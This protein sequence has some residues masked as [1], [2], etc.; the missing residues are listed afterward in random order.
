MGR[1]I[2]VAANWPQ[3]KFRPPNHNRIIA[4]Q[5]AFLHKRRVVYVKRFP[6]DRPAHKAPSFSYSSGIVGTRFQI[7]ARE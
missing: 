7:T 3:P 5:L 6:A 4:V 2:V 1:R